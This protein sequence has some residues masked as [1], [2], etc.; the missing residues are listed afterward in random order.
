M[1]SG[2][3]LASVSGKQMRWKQRLVEGKR[4]QQRKVLLEHSHRN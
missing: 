4:N 2:K 1:V 3:L